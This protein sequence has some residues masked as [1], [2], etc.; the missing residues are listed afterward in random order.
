MQKCQKE[1]RPIIFYA[2]PWE[3]DLSNPHVN[4]H[5]LNRYRHYHGIKNF[6]DRLDKITD[7]FRFTSFEKSNLWDFKE[8]FRY[9]KFNEK[10]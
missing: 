2:H 9:F 3:F 5:F 6:L 10:K 4:L 7:I 8:S 1:N